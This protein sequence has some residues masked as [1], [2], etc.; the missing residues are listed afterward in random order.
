[1]LLK[2]FTLLRDEKCI[3]EQ[4]LFKLV[5]EC[6]TEKNFD[7]EIEKRVT[8]IEQF[9]LRRAKN[10]FNTTKV[11]IWLILL[12]TYFSNTVTNAIQRYVKAS[13]DNIANN[14][15]A[16]NKLYQAVAVKF[17][18]SAVGPG[19]DIPKTIYE[20]MQETYNNNRDYYNEAF[21]VNI[22]ANDNGE[23]VNPE[24]VSKSTKEIT[25][26]LEALKN[27]PQAEVKAILND[28]FDTTGLYMLNSP[29]SKG[30]KYYSMYESFVRVYFNHQMEE[31]NSRFAGKAQV[32]LNPHIDNKLIKL[33][34]I[35]EDLLVPYILPG[36]SKR[37]IEEFEA[38]AFSTAKDRSAT[39][40][41]DLFG[42]TDIVI[43]EDTP[44]V[45]R[46]NF[47]DDL[48]FKSPNRSG[49]DEAPTKFTRFIKGV[50][51]L[52]KLYRYITDAGFTPY[53]IHP[54]LFEY[55]FGDPSDKFITLDELILYGSETVAIKEKYNLKKP[56]AHFKTITARDTGRL[57]LDREANEVV[58]NNRNEIQLEDL[59]GYINSYIDDGNG[60]CYATMYFN[61]IDFRVNL[62]TLAEYIK[63]GYNPLLPLYDGT[64]CDWISYIK[65]RDEEELF[66][67][68]VI[69]DYFKR[70]LKGPDQEIEELAVYQIQDYQIQDMRDMMTGD[71]K[72][73][74]DDLIDFDT[75]VQIDILL[76]IRSFVTDFNKEL[77]DYATR[78]KASIISEMEYATYLYKHE[79]FQSLHD[80]IK[81]DVLNQSSNKETV[82]ESAVI[83]LKKYYP[84]LT[85][86]K[87]KEFLT[88]SVNS[89][90]YNNFLGQLYS[91]TFPN[92]VKHFHSAKA[93][94][95]NLTDE[96]RE[97][98]LGIRALR[99]ALENAPAIDPVTKQLFVNTYK[100]FTNDDLGYLVTKTGK[101]ARTKNIN[102]KIGALHSSGVYVFTDGTTL[103]WK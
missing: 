91:T 83:L 76:A 41:A 23:S 38:V 16:A 36:I 47:G 69:K 100:Q 99:A 77:V 22:S 82:F 43:T 1:M 66:D 11:S 90:S 4:E 95:F 29:N 3:S 54:R 80:V 57:L 87:F 65:T 48:T 74:F 9:N 85:V 24:L 5:K 68:P 44:S 26:G 64:E 15:E 94:L 30:A 31:F 21:R 71:L 34:K 79:M 98:R 86:E 12:K 50:I 81:A 56:L 59:S 19:L 89:E 52:S 18:Q 88:R 63:R 102:N 7:E 53:H 58:I 96:G 103:P 25:S 6:G 39:N 97:I 32:S 84:E 8:S 28:I 17:S 37:N 42:I 73:L 72:G 55:T 45:A 27:I 33:D 2:I 93:N 40:V 60:E 14:V 70:F 67:P 35:L 20:Y 61:D 101:L 46:G 49:K 62:F 10:G 13:S 75:E 51:A 78:H 92:I